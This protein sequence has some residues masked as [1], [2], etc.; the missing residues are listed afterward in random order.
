MT[1]P[2]DDRPM[3]DH[4][5]DGIQEYD[6]PMPRW[7]LLLFAV[8][9]VIVPI[10][11]LVPGDIAYGPTFADASLRFTTDFRQLFVNVQ[12]L[13]LNPRVFAPLAL[14]L[15]CLRGQSGI[16]RVFSSMLRSLAVPSS[17]KSGVIAAWICSA[18]SRER[19]R[20]CIR[21]GRLPSRSDFK[22]WVAR[23]TA[24]STRLTSFAK[25]QNQ[26]M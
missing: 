4:S 15:G 20:Y 26:G 8:T 12:K 24:R 1:R 17:M 10:Y 19:L 9:I 5:Y 25:S 6:N 13:T 21:I 16:S 23:S 2:G 3:M 14:N 11:Y 7:W 18:V 22:Y